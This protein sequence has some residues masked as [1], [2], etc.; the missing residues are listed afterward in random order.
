MSTDYGCPVVINIFNIT[1]LTSSESHYHYHH[2]S[3]PSLLS[4]T[5]PTFTSITLTTITSSKHPTEQFYEDDNK[6]MGQQHSEGERIN[7]IP[8]GGE[9]GGGGVIK[10]TALCSSKWGAGNHAPGLLSFWHL[11]SV[12]TG[13]THLGLNRSLLS[14]GGPF[15]YLCCWHMTNTSGERG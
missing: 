5:T 1:T 7:G 15:L 8:R 14:I 9:G 3:V 13:H 12:C 2:F 6:E 10:G 4:V 11:V